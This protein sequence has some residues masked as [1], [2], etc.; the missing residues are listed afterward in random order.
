MSHLFA[1]YSEVEEVTISG[2]PRLQHLRIW[3]A[4]MSY[5]DYGKYTMRVVGHMPAAVE[6]TVDPVA[7]TADTAA[8]STASTSKAV[9][10]VPPP[11]VDYGLSQ[12]TKDPAI[13]KNCG[14]LK[15]EIMSDLVFD[16]EVVCKVIRQLPNL[17]SVSVNESHHEAISKFVATTGRSIGVC[18][19]ALVY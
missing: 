1:E 2:L 13:P 17:Y 18:S 6:R 4:S 16:E 19:F 5:V 3:C 14:L 8:S 11:R 10:T 12:Y 7:D 9:P 15:F